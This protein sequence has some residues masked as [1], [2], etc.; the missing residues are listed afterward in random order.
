MFAVG[1]SPGD[2]LREGKTV[3]R[4]RLKIGGRVT[5]R[6]RNWRR[7]EKKGARK[8]PRQLRKGQEQWKPG[9]QHGGDSWQ[10]LL[11]PEC[12]PGE[13]IPACLQI[14]V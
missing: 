9:E 10:L 13:P 5:E 2:K 11:N 12:C 1:Y 8:E 7:S 6:Q 3:E 4:E 14:R